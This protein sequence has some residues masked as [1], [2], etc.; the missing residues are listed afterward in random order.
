MAHRLVLLLF[1]VSGAVGLGYQVLWGRFLLDFIGVSA[2]SYAT[3]LAAFMAGLALG[4]ALL[5]RLADRVKSPLRLFAFLEAGVGLYALMYPRLSEAASALYSGLVS[6]TP[7]QA[8]AGHAL[9]AKVLV[10]GLLLLVPTTLMGG[11]YPA[12]VRHATNRLGQVGRK[13]SQ[14]YAVNALGAVA[15]ALLM[16]FALM[17]TLGMRLSLLVLALANGL[18]AATALLLARGTGPAPRVLTA[19]DGI[20]ASE[21][22]PGLTP[23]GVRVALALILV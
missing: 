15:G 23:L 16:A 7:E 9:W 3:V 8:G 11:T 14:L 13:A 10:A 2:W 17:P 21:I 1:L 20:G 12:L 4:S 22:G 5:G 18:V 19:Q 6:F